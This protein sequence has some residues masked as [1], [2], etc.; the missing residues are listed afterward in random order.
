MNPTL[1][2]IWKI[3]IGTLSLGAIAYGLMALSLAI[4]QNRLVFVPS[5]E[6]IATPDELGL[7]YEEVWLSPESASGGWVHSWWL[8][9]DPDNPTILYLH[10][11]GGNISYFL[12][13]IQVLRRLG[14]SLLLVDYRGYGQSEGQFPNEKRVY[15]DAKVAL[16][17]LLVQRRLDPGNLFVYGHSLG[18]AIAIHLASQHPELAG[19]ILEGTFTSMQ[20][21]A[22]F[23]GKY[24]WLPI[25]ALLH[26]RFDSRSKIGALSMPLLFIHGTDDEIVPAY[27][28]EMLYEAANAPKQ[29]LLIPTAKHNDAFAVGEPQYAGAIAD[30][31]RTHKKTAAN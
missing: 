2:W 11:N 8:P 17:H 22:D 23:V 26:Q 14:F 28:S 1:S 15:E 31:C 6:T 25:R 9:A 18:G 12:E 24:N 27:M 4:W 21:M 13:R 19:L 7:D 10:G 20:E 29:L 5:K 30:F 16:D 3:S